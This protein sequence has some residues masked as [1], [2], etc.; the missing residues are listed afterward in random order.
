MPPPWARPGVRTGSQGPV[1][2]TVRACPTSRSPH[3][4]SCWCV[5]LLRDLGGGG[6]SPRTSPGLPSI[7]APRATRGRERQQP[8]PAWE[9]S[10][11]AAAGSSASSGVQTPPRGT[12]PGSRHRGGEAR[13]AP[14]AFPGALA[15][16]RVCA[17][18][19]PTSALAPGTGLLRAPVGYLAPTQA[20]TPS[21]AGGA[22]C[23]GPEPSRAPKA[24][25]QSR[26]EKEPSLR[27]A[28]AFPK[29][30][31]TCFHARAK[32]DASRQSGQQ[33]TF[34]SAELEKSGGGAVGSVRGRRGQ[35]GSGKPGKENKQTCVAS[36]FVFSLLVSRNQLNHN[37]PP[38]GLFLFVWLRSLIELR[39]KSRSVRESEWSPGRAT[40]GEGTMNFS[41]FFTHSRHVLYKTHAAAEC[42]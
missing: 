9:V 4:N 14:F 34:L 2:E 41:P 1:G 18:A 11:R 40:G 31:H 20:P 37:K 8:R 21:R 25:S 16:G 5:C 19:H 30:L 10:P 22:N 7:Q 27:P 23:R 6:P 3:P 24:L 26:R 28:G 29:H 39:T 35:R 36:P 38:P 17:H 42:V 13:G 15:S 33:M 12:G 32:S